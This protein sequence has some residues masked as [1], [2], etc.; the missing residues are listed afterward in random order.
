MPV[1]RLAG[2][3]LLS[4]SSYRVKV[5]FALTEERNC[6]FPHP[7]QP[8]SAPIR[9]FSARTDKLAVRLGLNVEDLPPVIGIGRRTLFECRSAD[10][11]VS[12]KSWAKLEAAEQ[13][14]GIS[15]LEPPFA[16]SSRKVKESEEEDSGKI[17]EDPVAYGSINKRENTPDPMQQVLERIATSLEQLVEI[18][19]KK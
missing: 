2:G 9:T 15:C 12:Q 10:S 11:A 13:A 18:F 14:A 16:D 7:M 17:R 4:P 1:G 5:G 8:N 6:T 19:R 3:Y